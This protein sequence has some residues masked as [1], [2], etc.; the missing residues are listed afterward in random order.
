M[1]RLHQLGLKYQ[2]DKATYH[3]F[4]DDYE[5]FLSPY[6]INCIVEVGIYRGHSL[7]MWSEFY[8]EAKIIG[9]DIDTSSLINEY[10]ISSYI[11]DQNNPEETILPF[12][13][14][15]DVDLFIDDG[16][17]IYSHQINTF[18]AIFPHLKSKAIYILED[19]HTSLWRKSS[20]D[21][22][23]VTPLELIK[24]YVSK[25]NLKHKL[26]CL[27]NEQSISMLIEKD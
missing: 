26:V 17:H 27:N 16:S 5:L 22:T 20:Y 2:T 11:A 21:N 18:N 7:R 19:L 10:N 25:N 3:N 6:T 1:S 4:C 24:E 9:L 13:N 14:N 23:A 15:N 8:P 12:V